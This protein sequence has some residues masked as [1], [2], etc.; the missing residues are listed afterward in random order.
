MSLTIEQI[1]VVLNNKLKDGGLIINHTV[2]IESILE[3]LKSI[4]EKDTDIDENSIASIMQI[5][6][7]G[8]E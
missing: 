1:R 4:K 3:E 8:G 7:K 6:W 5:G 2:L